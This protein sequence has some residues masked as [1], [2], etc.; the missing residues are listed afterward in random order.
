MMLFASAIVLLIAS[1]ESTTGDRL[2][3]ASLPSKLQSGHPPRTAL[4]GE[5]VSQ[6]LLSTTNDAGV[7]VNQLEHEDHRDDHSRAMH[8]RL[9]SIS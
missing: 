2:F 4:Q 1:A 8:P 6:F 5:E 3:M 7:R 9:D